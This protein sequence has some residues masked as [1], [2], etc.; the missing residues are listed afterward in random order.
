[1]TQGRVRDR[2][3]STPLLEVL[4][5]V[6]EMDLDAPA[7][8][9]S[10]RAAI[11][12]Y[13]SRRLAGRDPAM[14]PA[15][16]A[17]ELLDR[18]GVHRESFLLARIVVDQ[19]VVSTVDTAL[20]NWQQH[21]AHSIGAAFDVEVARIGIDG[22]HVLEGADPPGLAR[23]MLT[24]LTW[25]LG[26]GFPEDEWLAV[27]AALAGAPLNSNH[28]SWVLDQL[29]RY[30][31]Q[32]GE[33]GLVVYRLAHQSLADHLR[34]PYQPTAKQPF[35]PAAAVV[36]AVLA[37]R[38]R[39]LLQDGHPATAPAYLWRYT[40]RHAA[41]TGPDGIIALRSLA[42]QDSA[43]APIPRQRTSRS[44]PPSPDGATTTTRCPPPKKPPRSFESWPPPTPPT[45]P[46]S[47]AR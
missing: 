19:L 22:F 46:P 16:I 11:A 24:A 26:A 44:R 38:Y 18:A 20:P 41:D 34:P 15:R 37:G 5:P 23:A 43:L 36:C 3:E 33:A 14:N 28:A 13:V 12:N 17:Q 9:E 4:A 27:A 31:V 21:L 45:C 32:D 30:I 47:P 8:Q 25:A 29:G 7:A 2:N 10:Q 6:A 35:D 1:M 39:Q 42:E 40:W